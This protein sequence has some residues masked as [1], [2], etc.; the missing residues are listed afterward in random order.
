MSVSE[1]SAAGMP[2]HRPLVWCFLESPTVALESRHKPKCDEADRWR[3]TALVA[4]TRW[5]ADNDFKHEWHPQPN[6]RWTLLTMAGPR[7]VAIAADCC[8]DGHGSTAGEPQGRAEI[9]SAVSLTLMYGAGLD[10]QTE[11]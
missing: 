11:P 1:S 10:E 9:E 6:G 2:T 7:V 3:T 8:L 4:A 5:A